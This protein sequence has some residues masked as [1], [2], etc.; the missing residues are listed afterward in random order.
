MGLPLWTL[1]GVG[2]SVTWITYIG[3]L[4]EKSLN[5]L[6][7]VEGAVW[8]F[9]YFVTEIILISGPA[10]FVAALW[11]WHRN[12]ANRRRMGLIKEE[13]APAEGKKGLILLVSKES[14]AM[15][16]IHY[17]LEKKNTLERLWLIPSDDSDGSR[18]GASTSP[19]ADQIKL[20]AESLANKL[21]K[22]LKV[23][24]H[25]KGVS[26]FD[27]QDTFEYVNRIFKRS[28]FEP[29]E[30]IADFTG[31]T[32][33]MTVGMIMA[34]LPRDRELEY[35]PFNSSRAEMD[36]PFVIEYQHSAFDLV[37]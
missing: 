6:F 34:C 37:G 12:E 17:H 10:I 5:C 18:F 26:P 3:K 14:H 9:K 7:H 22:K 13:L 24:I 11:V 21:G 30:I 16:A 4:G 33:P 1:I 29:D 35:V 2:V 36:G 31:G 32:K 20:S 27:S 23:E 25:E 15:H 28:G 19:I 8:S